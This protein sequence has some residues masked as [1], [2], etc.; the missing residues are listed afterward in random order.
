MKSIDYTLYLITDSKNVADDTFFS[1]L[2][3]ALKGGVTLVQLREKTLSSRA[4][5]E[6]AKAVKEMT[7]RFH[8]PLIIND[9]VDIALAV[10]ASGV[11]LGQDDLP[12]REARR[13]C[14]PDMILGVTAKTLQQ[15]LNA[16]SDGADYL[17]IGAIYASGTK[18]EARITPVSTASAIIRTSSL[19]AV[20]IGGLNADN[21]SILQDS[22]FS[23]IAIVSAIFSSPDPEKSARILKQEALSLLRPMH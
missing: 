4:L 3:A 15:G 6:K 22:P 20:A 5:Y 10:N 23:G 2:S 7:D 16:R 21:L 13:L 19:P 9:R 8:V 17:G 1:I 11:H 18:S 14:G 12:V